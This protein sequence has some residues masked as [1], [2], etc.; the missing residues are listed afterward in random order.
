MK[1]IRS[2]SWPVI[3]LLF[4]LSTAMAMIGELANPFRSILL[5]SFLLFCPG[6]AF[7][8]LLPGKD[9]I[10]HFILVVVLSLSI[11]TAIAQIFLYL[12]QWS[13]RLIL[14]TLVELCCLGALLKFPFNLVRS[15]PLPSLMVHSKNV[16]NRNRSYLNILQ[17]GWWVIFISTLA[18]LNFSVVYSYYI[19]TP[20]YEATAEFIVSSNLQNV[21]TNTK[22]DAQNSPDKIAI[23]STYAK[24]LSSSQI[25]NG[26]ME[27]M[28]E[29]LDNFTKYKISVTPLP[30]MNI[31][32]FSVNGPNPT[33]AAMLANSIG[34]YAI[35]FINNN[36]TD[37]HIGF[38]DK[39]MVPVAPSESNI[40]LNSFLAIILGLAI[41]S[42]LV[43]FRD[44]QRS[45]LMIQVQKQQPE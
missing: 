38:L 43:I 11:D 5:F 16:A 26:A 18:A 23:T 22:V 34:Q 30:D 33:V 3:I 39:A 44:K 17:H 19:A 42:G 29:N 10:T 12:G 15:A 40:V 2:Y 27:I 24:I 14:L 4:S 21:D 13:P 32:R 25:I 8:H 20:I 36:Y 28:H 37:S 31:I 45:S 35:I 7:N 9:Q 6:M 1:N 41:G